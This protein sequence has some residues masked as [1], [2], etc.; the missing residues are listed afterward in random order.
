MCV[1][2][3][4]AYIGIYLTANMENGK[5]QAI[6]IHKFGYEHEFFFFLLIDTY[7][8]VIDVSM[9]LN[10]V[11]EKKIIIIFAPPHFYIF[12]FAHLNMYNS[13]ILYRHYIT[14]CLHIFVLFI[15]HLQLLFSN[16]ADKTDRNEKR[17]REK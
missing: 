3:I 4:R 14:F 1:E 11:P 13:I 17:E 2:V 6:N 7:R 12:I 10:L 8:N 5:Y 16:L 15:S 9:V